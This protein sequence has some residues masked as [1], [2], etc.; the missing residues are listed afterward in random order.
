MFEHIESE[1]DV[2]ETTVIYT[3]AT[4]A[5]PQEHGMGDTIS[6]SSQNG[7]DDGNACTHG[8]R[9]SP[10][11]FEHETKQNMRSLQRNLSSSDEEEE[12]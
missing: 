4:A 5:M 7:V 6:N 10:I 9:S 2:G 11:S 3:A 12:E 1:T 8:Y